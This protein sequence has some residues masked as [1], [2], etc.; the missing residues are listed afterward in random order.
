MLI[1]FRA[2]CRLL[3]VVFILLSFVIV[4]MPIVGCIETFRRDK[5][6]S[7]A[8]ACQMLMCRLTL[9]IINVEI[10]HNLDAKNFSHKGQLLI[11]NHVSY[12][13]VLCIASLIP[14]C[15]LGKSEIQKW[16]LIRRVGQVAKAIYVVR[17]SMASRLSC[18]LKLKRELEFRNYTIFPEGT[19][20]TAISPSGDSW[21]DGFAYIASQDSL[22][23]WALALHY[24]NHFDRAWVDD[25][26]LIGHF[27]RTMKGSGIII[28][29]KAK[30]LNFDH[31]SRLRPYSKSV[32]RDLQ[33]D[34]LENYKQL[35]CET[36]INSVPAALLAK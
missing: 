16:P 6:A 19:T 28:S 3:S 27:W 13:D 5:S 24:D 9:K 35:N 18:L 29:I 14:T 17:E 25:M 2:V 20:S 23:V 11:A 34:C 26:N 12:F 7:I 22:N 32:L 31:D 10:R 15:F 4:I 30:K 1:L 36:R 8:L 21:F 33:N